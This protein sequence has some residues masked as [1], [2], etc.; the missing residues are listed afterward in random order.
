MHLLQG[1]ARMTPLYK[2]RAQSQALA[3]AMGSPYHN[4]IDNECCPDFS[5]CF[6]GMFTKDE[7]ER[8]DRYRKAYGSN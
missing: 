6:P 1:P 4:R 5:C 2:A 7:A 3:W 8:W